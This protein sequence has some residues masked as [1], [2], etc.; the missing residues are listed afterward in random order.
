[1]GFDDLEDAAA[2]QGGDNADTADDVVETES[3]PM[4]DTTQTDSPQ[5]EQSTDNSS[6]WKRRPAFPYD[7]ASQEAIYPRSDTWDEFEDTLDFVVKRKLR[8]AGIRDIPKRE[9]HEALLKLAIEH[10]QR[11]AELVKSGRKE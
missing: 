6:D 8:D 11:L 5:S 7:D 9:Y 10:P 2:E 3:S 1:M 4:Q